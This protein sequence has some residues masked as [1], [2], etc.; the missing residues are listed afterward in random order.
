[1]EDTPFSHGSFVKEP[2]SFLGINPQSTSVQKKF[3]LS[4][5]FAP[6]P[7]SFPEMGSA[8]PGAQ[9]YTLDPVSIV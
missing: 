5:V 9:F 4:P 1:L 6:K 7:L 3:Q 8:I 2:L